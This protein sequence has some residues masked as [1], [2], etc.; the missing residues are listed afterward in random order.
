MTKIV[1]YWK[2]GDDQDGIGR[3]VTRGEWRKVLRKE[4]RASAEQ[5]FQELQQLTD[6]PTFDDVADHVSNIWED[7]DDED[8]NFITQVIWS[9]RMAYGVLDLPAD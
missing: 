2:E 3:L 8:L 6:N 7:L 4:A 9:R 5:C 1:E